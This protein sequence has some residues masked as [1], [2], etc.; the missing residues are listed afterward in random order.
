MFD[1]IRQNACT[2]TFFIGEEFFSHRTRIDFT[3]TNSFRD[4][5]VLFENLD[6]EITLI[7]R[8]CTTPLSLTLQSI[9]W[10]LWLK[11]F[12]RGHETN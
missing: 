2:S 8:Y 3:L 9:A 11:T 4:L 10:N 6:I 12:E 1:P 5:T 7:R